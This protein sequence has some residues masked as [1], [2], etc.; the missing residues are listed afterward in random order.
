MIR[1][2]TIMHNQLQKYSVDVW[3][4]VE[5]YIGKEFNLF[6]ETSN[7]LLL[8]EYFLTLANEC[9]EHA[10]KLKRVSNMIHIDEKNNTL[11]IVNPINIL[12]KYGINLR[13]EREFINF[14]KFYSGIISQLGNIYCDFLK[15][16]NNME[17]LMIMK[18]LCDDKKYQESFLLTLID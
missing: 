14:V 6:S 7:N 12:R 18:K 17:V 13:S 3:A 16:T 2:G 10:F 8:K 5:N 1:N 15:K 4:E 11:N 9:H